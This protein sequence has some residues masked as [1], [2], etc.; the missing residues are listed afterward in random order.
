M[1]QHQTTDVEVSEAP[2]S[3]L[4]Q[5]GTISISFVVDRVLDV[6]TPRNGLGGIVLTERPVA[7]PYEI[8]HDSREG[9]GP[10][11]WPKRFDVSDWGLVFAEVDSMKVG[12]ALIAWNTPNLFM[13]EGRRDIAALW[14]L[15]VQPEFRGRRV[16]SR[17]VEATE[18]WAAAKG[19][20]SVTIETQNVNVR[21]CEF[22]ARC[23]YDLRSIDR[24]AYDDL[25]EE[26]RL[27]FRK[28]L[29]RT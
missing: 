4:G 7:E 13:L 16:G 6:S 1:A 9:E 22:Y 18:T 10:T 21:A 14:D 15:R 28:E 27:I 23:G 25:P 17:L 24:F 19:C 2:I 5:L 8:D 12:G 29:L 11:R 3:D 26:T 20:R